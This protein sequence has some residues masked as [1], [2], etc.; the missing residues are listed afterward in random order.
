M[1]DDVIEF[2]EAQIRFRNLV[3][4][5]NNNMGEEWKYVPMGYNNIEVLFTLGPYPDAMVLPSS[6]ECK[7]V[8]IR[9]D[10]KP[11]DAI[12]KSQ[13]NN[14]KVE[15]REG[16][17]VI[18]TGEKMLGTQR[19]MFW[20][21]DDEAVQTVNSSPCMYL[22]FYKRDD[23]IAMAKF[24]RE[25][26]LPFDIDLKDIVRHNVWG[27]KKRGDTSPFA[28]G[29]VVLGILKPDEKLIRKEPIVLY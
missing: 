16:C 4:E 7:K 18:I 11:G 6:K 27:Y 15:V 17:H 23:G 20:S 2:E 29:N 9:L 26:V 12:T 8:Y 28:S 25:V 13:I 1:N 21:V 3:K 14:I 19:P 22:D 5:F 24:G 10:F